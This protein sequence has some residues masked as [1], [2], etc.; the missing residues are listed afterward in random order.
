M[1]VLAAVSTLA[2]V[3]G[4]ARMPFGYYTLLRVVLCLTSAVGVAASRR[5]R[6]SAWLWV[7]GVLVV[8]Y[9]P[10]LPVHLGAKRL[11]IGVNVLTLIFVW[12]GAFR[13]RG[14]MF[15]HHLTRE[16]GQ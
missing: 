3:L 6:D 12:L 1:I 10:I 13:F 15:E 11:W 7:Y 8:L 14:L 9:N 16:M 5:Q 4:L 2:V